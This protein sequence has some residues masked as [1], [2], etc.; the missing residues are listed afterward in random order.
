LGLTVLAASSLVGEDLGILKG[1]V[2]D[3]LGARIPNASVVIVW[4]ME[5]CKV[6]HYRAPRHSKKTKF[7]ANNEGEYAA[8][9]PPGKYQVIVIRKPYRPAC[10]DIEIKAGKMTELHVTLEPPAMRI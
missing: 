5:G 10:K 3:Q 9:L 2:D 4:N 6:G 8:E 7:V 1:I